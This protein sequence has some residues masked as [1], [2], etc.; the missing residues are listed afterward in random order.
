MGFEDQY[1]FSKRFR[2]IIG[3]SPKKY[4]TSRNGGDAKY[5]NEGG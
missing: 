2:K 1:Y 5:E 4:R 3:V